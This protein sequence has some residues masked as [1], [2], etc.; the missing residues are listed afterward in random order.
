MRRVLKTA[1]ILLFFCWLLACSDSDRQQFLSIGTAPPGG[2][3]FVV[4]GAISEVLGEHGAALG[5]RIT[6]E[7]TMGSQENIRRLVTGELNLALSNSAITY[8][9]VRGEGEWERP[10]SIRSVMTLA[11]NV[12]LFVTPS[13]S[14]IR[15]IGDLRGKRVVIGPAGAG[16]EY[17]VRPLLRGHG[18]DYE[19]LN[20][21][22]GTQA[23]AVDMMAD[24]TA[25]AAF[26]GGAIPTASI[27]QAAASQDILFVPFDEEVRLRL[28]DEHPFFR[29]AVIPAGTYR[30]QS[31]DFPGLD[32]GS[33]HLI[34]SADEDEELIYQVTRILYEQR[35]AVQER[36]PAGGSINPENAVRS[37]GTEFHPGA[38][39][40]FREIGIWPEEASA[41]L[42]GSAFESAFLA[43]VSGAAD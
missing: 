34:T 26:L 37:T 35:S 6:A 21:L 25:A 29:P 20:V 24:G 27:S 13:G 4:G 16:F 10:Y 11:P 30:G 42:G 14:G 23:A 32:V 22:F 18:V 17:F 33:M 28:V 8:Y 2:A 1:P 43:H 36:H 7:A 40:Y 38:I 12:A 41:R 15:E 39:R 5:W 31:E 9:A 3:F 19:E